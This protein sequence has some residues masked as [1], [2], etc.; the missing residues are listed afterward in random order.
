MFVK[1]RACL[2]PVEPEGVANSLKLEL[3]AVMSH[4]IWV[5]GTKA[6]S[7]AR[8]SVLS[9]LPAPNTHFLTFTSNPNRGSGKQRYS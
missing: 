2:V 8:A 9:C 5:L 7:F 3:Q 6:E 1:P 4:M